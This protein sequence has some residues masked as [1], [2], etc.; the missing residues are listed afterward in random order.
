MANYADILTMI[1][2]Q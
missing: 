2:I 1:F